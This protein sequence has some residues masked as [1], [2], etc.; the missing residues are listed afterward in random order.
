MKKLVYVAVGVVIAMVF[1]MVGYGSYLNYTNEANI[2]QRTAERKMLVEGEVAKKVTFK[3]DYT[4][5]NV[6]VFNEQVSDVIARSS[7]SLEKLYVKIGDYVNKGDPLAIIASEELE[8]KLA[9]QESVVAKANIALRRY[10]QGYERHA[11]LVKDG[12]VSLDN[13]DNAKAYYENA[14]ADLQ[15]AES[16]LK[17]YEIQRDRLT[18]RAPFSGRVDWPYRGVGDLISAGTPIVRIAN[19]SSKYFGV[20]IEDY[21]VKNMLPLEQDWFA[22]FSLMNRAELVSKQENMK[23]AVKVLRVIPSLDTPADMR[24]VFFG[25]VDKDNHIDV[26]L[27]NSVY[28][29][30]K[31]EQ[32]G[33]LI[34][35]KAI[36]GH[37]EKQVFV[38]NKDKRLELRKVALGARYGNYIEV[39]SGVQDGDIVVVA[40]DY[41]LK[42]GQL[43]DVLVKEGK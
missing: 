3:Q 18:L 42:S 24:M 19:D 8:M 21:V 9:E 40:K 15:V 23:A 26:A 4:F 12:A 32:K 43:V 31:R 41:S 17:Q 36:F 16:Q 1:L 2:T 28:L 34:P 20:S 29:Q 13:Y 22:S 6:R 35:I 30:A 11:R 37:G 38:W 5:D 7:G 39:H 25:I 14:I 10:Q 33:V 27:Y